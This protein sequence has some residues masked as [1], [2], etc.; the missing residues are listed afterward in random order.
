M[1]PKTHTIP[2]DDIEVHVEERGLGP[3]LLF[4]HGLGGSGRDFAHLFDLDVLATHYRVL[5]PDARGHGRSTNPGG[6]FTIRRCARDVLHLL[7]IL[8][9][10]SALAVGV[11]LGALTLLHIAAQAPPRIA[12][13]ILVSAT[14]RFPAGARAT[15][16]ATGGMA[17]LL[18]EAAQEDVDF[19]RERLGAITADTLIVSGDRDPLYPVELAVDLYRGIPHAAL[20]VVPGGGH[21]PVFLAERQAFVDRALPFF[22]AGMEG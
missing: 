8:R 2:V 17:A 12:R 15:M 19:A 3:P 22:R 5:A 16:Q 4:L 10:D 20:Y 11:S 13:M 9:V 1:E 6:G 7:D 14:T 21:S 18:A